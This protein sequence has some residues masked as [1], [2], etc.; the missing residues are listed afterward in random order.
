MF[1]GIVERAVKLGVILQMHSVEMPI[2]P[3]GKNAWSAEASPANIGQGKSQKVK[4]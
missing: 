4:T 2:S 3:S 1:W